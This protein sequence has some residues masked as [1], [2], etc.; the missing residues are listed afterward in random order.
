[1]TESTI[2]SYANPTDHAVDLPLSL[3]SLVITVPVGS[4]T[5]G[6]VSYALTAPE[7]HTVGSYAVD[8]TV[9]G[10]LVLDTTN[11]NTLRVF[12]DEFLHDGIDVPYEFDSSPYD[13]ITFLYQLDVPAG[14]TD[15]STLDWYRWK[16]VPEP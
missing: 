14:A 10:A 16:I 4:V 15:L 8:C 6:G 2:I 7:T 13:L 12:V 5:Y 9:L 3:S 1:M 11:S